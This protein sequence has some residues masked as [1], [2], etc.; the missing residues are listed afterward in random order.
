MP[1]RQ[2][3]ARGFFAAAL[4]VALP[5]PALAQGAAPCAIAIVG[6]TVIDGN[7]GPA[8]ADATV[9]VRDGKFAQVGKR[10]D[11]KVPECAQK[12]DG[13]GKYL[14]PG[15]VDTNV[16]NAMPGSAI[17][18]ARYW[19][20]LTDIAIEGAQ[21]HLKYGVTSIR[22]SYGTLMPLLAAR[23]QIKSG[24]AIGARMYVAG[25][26]IGWGGTFSKTFRG[27]DPENY[28]EE[29]LNDQI[30]QGA[31]ELMPWFGPDSL[32]VI[33]NAY[34]DKGVDFVK[35]GGTAHSQTDPGLVF[36]E[37][38]F[39]AIVDAVHKRGLMAETHSTTP[40][41]MYIALVSGIDLIQHPEV[42][43]VPIPDEIL[44]LLDEKRPFCSIHGNNHAGRAY[45]QAMARS[46]AG[47]G[48][49]GGASAGA[50]RGDP[51][52][53]R[54]WPKPKMTEKGIE[55]SIR[56]TNSKVM[57][58]NAEKIVKTRCPIT[59]ATDNAVAGAPE[60]ARDPNA[61]G[62][63]EP[64]LGTLASI[65]SLVEFGMT[66]AQA[67]VAG[68]KNGAKALPHRIGDQLG[69][70]EPGKIADIV[71]LDADPLADIKNIR[72]IRMV[73]KDGAIIDRDKLPTNPV[74]YRPP[75]AVVP[76]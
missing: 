40:E 59:T 42:G 71:M 30:T 23:D 44:K 17:D 50:A 24:K 52:E 55:D 37:R 16:H 68:T 15:F 63:R 8:L 32:R 2:P 1:V 53:L 72:K 29:F 36:S 48:G 27:R 19:D 31:G 61:W 18:Y 26:I 69:T 58:G 49:A 51:T 43:G 21:L 14:T 25:N 22:D 33:V 66:P 20:R 75:S 45:Q 65:E 57:R 67:I 3:S 60:F 76:E 47:A 12:V 41:G 10:A 34:I 7:G 62:A 39:K 73:M 38:Q 56:A 13:A 64:G 6:A 11:V 9:L 54:K 28:Y 35:I 4:L 5:L 70:I 46:T 74:M